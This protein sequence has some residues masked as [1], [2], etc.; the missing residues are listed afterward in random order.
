M[1]RGNATL[2]REKLLAA[3]LALAR[4][5]S[6]AEL[7]VDDV[8]AQ[9]GV[10]KGTFY[11]HFPDRGAFLAAL[12]QRFHDAVMAEVDA[13][14][15]AAAAGL[16]RLLAGSLA[17]LDYCRRDHPIKALLIGA[18]VEPAIQAAVSAQN[19]RFAQLAEHS[20]QAAGWPAPRHA[21][22]L[23]VGLVAEA[24]LAEA[25]AGKTLPA[26]RKALAAFLHASA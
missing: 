19:A 1:A 15:A 6:F 16:S 8:V 21:G 24:A 7:R 10:A 20:F 25:E 12:H 5:Q 17:Y 18:R 11:L 9:A 22:R 3:G 23:W 13:A 4:T 2:T 26:L 14:T